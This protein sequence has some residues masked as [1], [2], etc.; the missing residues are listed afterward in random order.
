M[1]SA[2]RTHDSYLS[3]F[4]QERRHPCRSRDQM[5]AFSGFAPPNPSIEGVESA[6]EMPG[7]GRPRSSSARIALETLKNLRRSTCLAMS[8]QGPGNPWRC[9]CDLTLKSDTRWM[10]RPFSP[11]GE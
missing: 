5:G 3:I 11:K 1:H 10:P 2:V 8:L 7:G 6:D 4:D 9:P